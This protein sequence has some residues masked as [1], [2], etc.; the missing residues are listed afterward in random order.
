MNMSSNANMPLLRLDPDSMHPQTRAMMV[1]ALSEMAENLAMCVD[2]VGKW[3]A[4]SGATPRT[5]TAVTALSAEPKTT[6]SGRALE[7]TRADFAQSGG[8][9]FL[10]EQVTLRVFLNRAMTLKRIQLQLPIKLMRKVSP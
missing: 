10:E 4:A 8:I 5:R 7:S 2:S 1:A 3:Q 6:A 9:G